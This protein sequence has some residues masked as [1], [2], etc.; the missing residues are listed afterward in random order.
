MFL[1][2]QAYKQQ[3]WQFCYDLASE[4]IRLNPSKVWRGPAMRTRPL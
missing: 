3:Q 4:A 1:F 2:L